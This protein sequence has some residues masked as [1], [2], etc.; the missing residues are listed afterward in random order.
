MAFG[1]GDVFKTI[2]G[3]II[4]GLFGKEAEESRS[5]SSAAATEKQIEFAREQ[6]ARNEALQREFAQMGVRWRVEDAKAAGLHPLY[7][8]SSGGAAFAP[9]PVVMPAVDPGAG[10]KGYLAQ[11]GQ[12]LSRAISAQQTPEQRAVQDAQLVVLQAQARKDLA[13]ASYYDSLAARQGGGQVG[14]GMPSVSNPPFTDSGLVPGSEHVTTEFV[15]PPDLRAARGAI[16]IEP[17]TLVSSDGR[18]PYVTASPGK[19][20]LSEYQFGNGFRM[21]LPAA[22]DLGEALEPLS[23][24]P[25][26]TL[27]VIGENIDHYGFSWIG[28]A[29]RKIPG[30]G[31]IG[32]GMDAVREAIQ[33]AQD[34][35][36]PVFDALGHRA[37]GWLQR[38][39]EYV[40]SRSPRTPPK[41][42][43]GR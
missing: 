37:G 40:R 7:A 3:P 26:Q 36:G 1:I 43:Y 10:G 27:F 31:A 42:P 30:L 25:L 32:R 35:V 5:D 38:Q 11:M 22:K 24:S 28:H 23:E 4:G 29:A 6:Q 8:L 39:R 12:D 18:F 17:D 16:K 21:L 9:N 15:G 34:E 2:A 41:W 19:P 14:P 20:G 33:D 13:Q